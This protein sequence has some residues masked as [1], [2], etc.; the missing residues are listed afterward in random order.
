VFGEDCP[1][2]A[3]ADL[4]LDDMLIDVKTTM[5]PC[6]TGQY[7]RQMLG[8]VALNEYFPIGGG[9]PVAI[10]RIGFYFSRHGCLASWPLTEL[11]DLKRLASFAAWLRNYARRRRKQ[12]MDAERIAEQG[13]RARK[14]MRRRPATPRHPEVSVT[15]RSARRTISK[16]KVTGKRPR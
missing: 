7:W 5:K 15:N 11:L 2:G 14:A 16:K 1:V 9:K 12:E 13:A 3:D 4:L 6:V 8:Y 10:R